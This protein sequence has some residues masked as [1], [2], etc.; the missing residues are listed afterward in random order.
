MKIH[1]SRVQFIVMCAG[2]C[3]FFTKWQQLAWHKYSIFSLFV[4]LC[5]NGSFW[6]VVC[7][8]NFLKLHLKTYLITLL[9]CKNKHL[10]QDKKKTIKKKGK[11]FSL[12]WSFLPCIENVCYFFLKVVVFFLNIY[13][14][15]LDRLVLIFLFFP[16]LGEFLAFFLL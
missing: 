14:S 16:N 2:V 1:A 11:H 7:V 8:Q 12:M 4:H 6:H 13:F 3:C 10:M 5:E 15:L 9:P